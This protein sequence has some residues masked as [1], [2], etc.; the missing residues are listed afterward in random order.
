MRGNPKL[1]ALSSPQECADGNSNSIRSKDTNRGI[2][3]RMHDL[4]TFSVVPLRVPPQIMLLIFA[5]ILLMA[6]VWLL[7]R[8]FDSITNRFRTPSRRFPTGFFEL[9][10]YLLSKGE[11]AFLP[12]LEQAI[13]NQFR[14]AMKVRL[15]DLVGVPGNGSE[16]ITVHNKIRQKHVDFVLC[17][18]SAVKPVLAIELDDSSHDRPDRIERDAYLDACLECAGLPICHVRCRQAYDVEQL[19]ADINARIR[20]T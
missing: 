8:F 11:N 18:N 10:P 4:N 13:G 2:V 15:G 5:M 9:R 16:V 7:R 3:M 17:T 1:E 19:A 6:V 12:A 20:R 14:I